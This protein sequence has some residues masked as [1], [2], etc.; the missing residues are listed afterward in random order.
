MYFFINVSICIRAATDYLLLVDI[1]NIY[2][3]IN[4]F[5]LF[6]KAVW[7]TKTFNSP[8]RGTDTRL[9]FI[10]QHLKLHLKNDYLFQTMVPP[11]NSHSR[12]HLE[13]AFKDYSSLCRSFLCFL[14]DVRVYRW[15][16][17]WD[18]EDK[19]LSRS[20]SGLLQQQQLPPLYKSSRPQ[21]LYLQPDGA[22]GRPTPEPSSAH[23][24]P[25]ALENTQ[26]S[27]PALTSPLLR[28]PG[29]PPL[30]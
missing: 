23:C 18:K 2:C 22:R 16:Y 17:S 14:L 26:D 20:G 30:Q 6:W 7:N 28:T 21:S 3:H 24:G 12:F 27:W 9:F 15:R 25:R 1:L 5:L 19:S 13:L 8:N 11:P 10:W 4:L 29:T